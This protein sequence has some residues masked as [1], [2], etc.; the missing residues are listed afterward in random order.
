MTRCK[1]NERAIGKIKT[2][3]KYLHVDYVPRSPLKID[4]TINNVYKTF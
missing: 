3:G 2:K 1:L 4:V